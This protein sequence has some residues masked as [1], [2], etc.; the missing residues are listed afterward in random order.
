MIS[1]NDNDKIRFVNIGKEA[2]QVLRSQSLSKSLFGN[3]LPEPQLC[4]LVE[5]IVSK[6]KTNIRTLSSTS[7]RV[8][9]GVLKLRFDFF[10]RFFVE[11]GS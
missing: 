2:R 7:S 9:H 5:Q 8:I 4:K 3:R 1:L 11:P 10:I 6:K